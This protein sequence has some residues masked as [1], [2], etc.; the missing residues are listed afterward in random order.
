M[1]D[2]QMYHTKLNIIVYLR[3]EVIRFTLKQIYKM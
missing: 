3:G 1:L 2:F